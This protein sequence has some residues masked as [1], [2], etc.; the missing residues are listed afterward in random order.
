[1]DGIRWSRKHK[2]K[3]NNRQILLQLHQVYARE[4]ESY[5]LESTD[6]I[7]SSVCMTKREPV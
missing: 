5:E 4:R 2:L 7:L 1:M 3:L 6:L